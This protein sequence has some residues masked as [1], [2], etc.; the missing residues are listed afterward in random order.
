MWAGF[1]K[2]PADW[3]PRLGGGRKSSVRAPQSRDPTTRGSPVW[4]PAARRRLGN[5]EQSRIYGAKRQLSRGL[6]IHGFRV[7]SPGPPLHSQG[8]PVSGTSRTLLVRSPIHAKCAH[9]TERPGAH[10]RLRQNAIVPGIPHPTGLSAPPGPASHSTRTE[11]E[12][13]SRS[14]GIGVRLARPGVESSQRPGRH[15]Y[16]VERSVAWLGS[17]RRLNVRWGRKGLQLPGHARHRLRPHLRQA[18]G[19]AHRRLLKGAQ[20]LRKNLKSL[21]QEG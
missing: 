18:P 14:N 10:P 12:S 9:L 15:R 11:R 21:S 20:A 6:L 2:S 4:S 17:Y 7:R 1:A 13:A 19:H 5:R 16:K 8:F 3:N